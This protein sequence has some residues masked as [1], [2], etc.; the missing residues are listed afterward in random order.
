MAVHQLKSNQNSRCF[1]KLKTFYNEYQ[2]FG[3]I[4]LPIND[5][6]QRKIK[7]FNCNQDKTQRL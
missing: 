4:S 7:P 1:K 3:N 5:S 6:I 2:T